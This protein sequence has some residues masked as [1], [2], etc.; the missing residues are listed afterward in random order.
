MAEIFKIIVS[1]YPGWLLEADIEHI[2]TGMK[3]HSF[4]CSYEEAVHIALEILKRRLSIKSAVR[5]ESLL[6]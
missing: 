3:T 6:E 4:G 2:A 1:Q 5:Q